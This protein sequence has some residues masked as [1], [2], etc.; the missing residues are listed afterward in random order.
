MS[1]ITWQQIRAQAA[2]IRDARGEVLRRTGWTHERLDAEAAQLRDACNLSDLTEATRGIL[3]ILLMREQFTISESLDAPTQ[4]KLVEAMWLR[5]WTGEQF[6]KG[7]ADVMR[8]L[9]VRPATIPRGIEVL[10]EIGRRYRGMKQ[11]DRWP[12]REARERCAET[13]WLTG[14]SEDAVYQ[15]MRAA[16]ERFEYGRGSEAQALEALQQIELIY[17]ETAFEPVLQETQR[18]VLSEIMWLWGWSLQRTLEE[19]VALRT[20]LGMSGVVQ[21]IETLHAVSL[22]CGGPITPN[23]VTEAVE[24]IMA[25]EDVLP[26][27]R[28]VVRLEFGEFRWLRQMNVGQALE[29]VR[30]YENMTGEKRLDVFEAALES[31]R[32]S[33]RTRQAEAEMEKP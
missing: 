22:R 32:E 7:L 19:A 2:G 6:R 3:E 28:D 4:L 9:R 24:Y 31:A 33:Y 14:Q 12:K 26:E 21:P 10:V 17:Q 29:R 13:M 16:M 23:A 18:R 30:R 5:S 11:P 1:D 8:R 25:G 20:R 27:F 15:A